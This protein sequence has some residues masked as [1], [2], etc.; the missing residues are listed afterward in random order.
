MSN[1]H[2]SEDAGLARFM[3]PS[4][5]ISAPPSDRESKSHLEKLD[6]VPS[7]YLGANPV[8]YNLRWFGGMKPSPA[9]KEQVEAIATKDNRP[10]RAV[11]WELVRIGLVHRDTPASDDVPIFVDRHMA[12]ILNGYASRQRRSVAAILRR[13]LKKPDDKLVELLSKRTV[14]AAG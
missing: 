11:L 5:E 3:D 9:L 13:L 4:A 6:P 8:P 7:T 14:S 2:E 1:V 10:V 12:S